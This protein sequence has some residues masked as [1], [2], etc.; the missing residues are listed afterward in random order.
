MAA[1]PAANAD[2]VDR[3]TKPAA[4]EF[5]GPI[6]AVLTMFALPMVAFWLIY[7]VSGQLPASL[8]PDLQKVLQTKGSLCAGVWLP[9]SLAEAG[10]LARAGFFPL[11]SR[12]AAVVYVSW[13]VFQLLLH[14]LLP[15]ARVQGVPL[16]SGRLSYRLNGWWALMVTLVLF[17][18]GGALSVWDPAW[19]GKNLIELFCAMNIFAWCQAT[20]L[21]LGTNVI[22]LPDMP[23]DTATGVAVYDFFMGS[24]RNPR[25]F[26]WW[27]IK[28]F[29][30]SRPGLI[31]WVLINL[32]LAWGQFQNK[33]YVT[34]SLALVNFFQ[35]CYIVDYFWQEASILTTMDIMHDS[36]G[37]MLSFGDLAWVPG[38][39]SLQ[40][41]YLYT[42]PEV[43]VNMMCAFL[44][45]ILQVC[46][47]YVFRES[48]NQKHTF[49]SAQS[50]SDVF[51]KVRIWG[52]KP[53]FVQT[54]RGTK[55]LAAGWWGLARHPNYLGDVMMG[56]AWSLPCKFQSLAP[57]FYPI[58][59]WILLVH[60]ERRDNHHCHS[61]YT[62]DW[63]EYSRQVPYRIIPYLY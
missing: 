7:S 1:Q 3:V 27:D 37:F 25:A 12:Q 43:S 2:G 56:L 18:L 30:E 60:R 46:G 57:Y 52:R 61:K 9:S 53:Q 44:I 11:P 45:L 63:E 48:N 62:I 34:C 41:L 4:D 42:H 40:A 38:L 47:Y 29:C 16:P 23:P 20:F 6:G 10:V 50:N 26:G 39:Y 36:F 8:G 49:R 19:L 22:K 13:Y 21:W 33:G 59:F 35:L 31:L 55:L 28:F 14:A 24:S 32:S 15:G 54:K 5:G 17:F 58:Y 51:E